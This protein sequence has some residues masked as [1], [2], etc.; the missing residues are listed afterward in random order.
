M[1][2][3]QE[4]TFAVKAG[5]A[6]MLKGGVIMDVTNVEEARIAEEAGACAVMALERVPADIRRRA[7]VNDYSF[8]KENWDTRNEYA[9]RTSPVFSA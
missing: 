5:L 1:S 3:R 7:P 2:D 4:A 8:I 9:R 6:Q